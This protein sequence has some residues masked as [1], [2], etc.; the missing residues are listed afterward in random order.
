MPPKR[1]I[2]LSDEVREALLGRLEQ[3]RETSDRAREAFF[4]DVYLM[5][6][7]GLTEK[8]EAER[9]GVSSA[10]VNDWKRRGE[11]AWRRRE[12]DGSRRLGID[13]DGPPELGAVS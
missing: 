9:L 1:K 4:V 2:T 10:T 3:S 5:N 13:P 11:E 12:E 7:A 8:E 6:R